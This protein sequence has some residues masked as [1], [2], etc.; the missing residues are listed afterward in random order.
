M[1]VECS[2]G[3]SAKTED[4]C[5]ALHLASWKGHIDL[6]WM[7]T[8]HDADMSAQEEH[9][10]TMLHLALQFGHL[11]IAWMLVEHGTDVPRMS[12][13][14]LCCIWHPTMAMWILLT[15]WPRPRIGG[16]HFASENGNIDLIQV[17]VEHRT[18]MAHCIYGYMGG[19]N[20]GPVTVPS[21]LEGTV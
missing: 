12:M 3:T 13:V 5:T 16:L 4:R 7:L 6:A 10:Q 2:A 14:G 11:N 1:L 20:T 17:L 9:K 8:E 21:G 18:N 19:C 15:C